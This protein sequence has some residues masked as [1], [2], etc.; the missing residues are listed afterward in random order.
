MWQE[1]QIVTGNFCVSGWGVSHT[2][3]LDEDRPVALLQMSVQ[4]GSSAQMLW[5]QPVLTTMQ[6]QSQNLQQLSC[7]SLSAIAMSGSR[8]NVAVLASMPGDTVVLQLLSVSIKGRPEEI[9]THVLQL[10]SDAGAK[11]DQKGS[12]W[13]CCCGRYNE[14]L[15]WRQ[16]GTLYKWTMQTG[17]TIDIQCSVSHPTLRQGAPS[18]LHIL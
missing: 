6:H 14:V 4:P 9:S 10:G 13:C 5:S 8:H 18:V 2:E 1:A 17:T 11:L 16:G 15:I 3:T 7:C 12:R